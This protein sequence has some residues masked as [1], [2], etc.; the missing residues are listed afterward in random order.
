MNRSAILALPLTLSLLATTLYAQGPNQSNAAPATPMAL[1]D[2]GYIFKNHPRYKASREAIQQKG[3]KLQANAIE[4]RKYLQSESEKLQKMQP[5]SPEF[6][7]LEA[8]LTQL[9]SDYQVKNELERKGLLE[10]EA[11]LYYETYREVEVAV[12]RVSEQYGFR[13]VMRFDR[14]KMDPADPDSIRRGLMNNVVYQEGL[15]ITDMVLQASAPL[16]SNTARPTNSQR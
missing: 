4:Q 2:L 8:E 9:A 5:G 3:K 16:V 11:K 7:R 1:L 15:D 6:K 12:Q 14:E 13:L 10:D